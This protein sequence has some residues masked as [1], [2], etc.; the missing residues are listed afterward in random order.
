MIKKTNF[1]FTNEDFLGGKFEDEFQS[2]LQGINIY[3]DS[4]SN[5]TPIRPSGRWV[6]E[7]DKIMRGFHQMPFIVSTWQSNV[8]ANGS[9]VAIVINE[10]NAPAAQKRK[11]AVQGRINALIYTKHKWQNIELEI[12]KKIAIEGNAVVM[13][14][15]EGLLIVESINRFNIYFDAI[16]RRNRYAYL[17]NGAEKTGMTD[18]YH[19]V[20]LWHFKDPIGMD[21]PLAPSRLQAAMAMILLDN[22]A[23]RMNTHMFANGFLSNVFLKFYD[24]ASEKATELLSDPTKDKDGKTWTQRLLDSIRGKFGGVDN[25]GKIG[26]VPYLEDI[27]KVNSSNKDSQYLQI[28]KELT[29]ERV[30]W[31]YSMTLTDFGAGRATTYNNVS[32]FN[33]A[34]YD[35]FGRAM[36]RQLDQCRNE[37]V[38]KLEGIST[39]ETLYICY[40]EPEDPNKLLEAAAWR[41]DWKVDVITVNEYREK[42]HL[43]PI[44]GGDVTYSEWIANKVATP[45]TTDMVPSSTQKLRS[46]PQLFTNAVEY[47]QKLTPVEK[48]L[49]TKEY[50]KFNNRWANAIA[51]QMKAFLKGFAGAKNLDLE[52]FDGTLPKIESFYAFNVL[53]KDLLF[54]AG[55]GLDEVKKD[56]R[57]KFKKDFW[58]GEYPQSV[59]DAIEK[60]TQFLL[61]GVGD[62][63]GVDA[64]T[65]QVI[66][67]YIRDN[68]SKGVEGISKLLLTL[69]PEFAESRARMIA[70]TEVAEAVEGTREIMYVEEFPDG[71]KEW[72]TTVNDV[73][74]LCKSNGNEGNMM[75]KELFASGDSRAP[76]HPRCRCTTLYYPDLS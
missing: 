61:K 2:A 32:V 75:I 40:N 37:F 24:K 76:A 65:T 36:E 42:R 60:R 44:D 70:Q 16:N 20:D 55:L 25:A 72:Q 12:I 69:M 46:S 58:D 74:Q 1:G 11:Q 39:S 10:G 13:I 17:I 28:L 3:S 22:K 29:P 7:Y 56:E 73:C 52:K 64:Q 34:L 8:G 33:D 38:L 47:A 66:N 48:A 26:I 67:Q 14:N 6:T 41:E 71:A 27:I 50:E 5:F 30:A 63:E 35:K 23:T 15:D 57:V 68:A 51:K 59:L 62:Y 45:A 31:A 9:T 49:K 43:P 19:G 54:F 53:K 4:D 21:M 18:L